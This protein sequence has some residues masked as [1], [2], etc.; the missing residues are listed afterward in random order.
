MSFRHHV[1]HVNLAAWLWIDESGHG[2]ARNCRKAYRH[3][4]WCLLIQINAVPRVRAGE[5]SK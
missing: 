3:L 5:R 4:A 2:A 1:G